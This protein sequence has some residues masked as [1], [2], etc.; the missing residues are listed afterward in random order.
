MEWPKSRLRTNLLSMVEFLHV[1]LRYLTALLLV[2]K[3][4]EGGDEV[5]ELGWVG[6]KGKRGMK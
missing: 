2:G 1:H 6:K 3:L 4:G 5:V